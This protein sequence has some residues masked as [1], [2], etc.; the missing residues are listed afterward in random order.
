[1]K[2][3]RPVQRVIDRTVAGLMADRF[4]VG[5]FEIGNVQHL[6][7]AAA[8]QSASAKF[9]PPRPTSYSRVCDRH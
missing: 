6:A 4:L 1:M 8:W 7:G 3:A 9:P 2:R 5:R